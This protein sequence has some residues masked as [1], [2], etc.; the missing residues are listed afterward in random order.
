LLVAVIRTRELLANLDRLLSHWHNLQDFQEPV[1]G[2]PH[3]YA[4]R[5]G[6][7]FTTKTGFV[8][9][10]IGGGQPSVGNR[11]PTWSSFNIF[12]VIGNLQHFE[13]LRS[14]IPFHLGDDRTHPLRGDLLS[15]DL[16]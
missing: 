2:T 12:P 10:L 14:I 15:G 1:F 5:F 8:F 6:F 11:K 3:R 7:D 16:S 13:R 4:G 9:G